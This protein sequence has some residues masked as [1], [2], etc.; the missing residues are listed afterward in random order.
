[1]ST[2]A[3]GLYILMLLT[4]WEGGPL[5]VDVDRLAR[6]I[7]RTREEIERCW[8]ELDPLFVEWPDGL[9]NLRLEEEREKQLAKHTRRVD[10]GRRGGIR[11]GEVRRRD[12]D[13]DLDGEVVPLRARH[14]PPPGTSG[15]VGR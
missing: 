1:M 8:P 2:D 7:G 3:V 14:N 5:P 6:V 12:D 9:V 13:N 4:E 15:V 11:S 10:A